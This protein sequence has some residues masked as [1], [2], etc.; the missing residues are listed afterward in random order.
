MPAPLPLICQFLDFGFGKAQEL[1][2]D[3]FGVLAKAKVRG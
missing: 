3:D 1:F 2:E